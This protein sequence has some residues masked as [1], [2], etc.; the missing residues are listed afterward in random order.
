MAF[1]IEPLLFSDPYRKMIASLKK[2]FKQDAREEGI[3]RDIRAGEGKGRKGPTSLSRYVP[4]SRHTRGGNGKKS[5]P[6]DREEKED[7]D[8]GATAPA[9]GAV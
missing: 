2:M 5:G 1:F 4:K 6:A 3:L 9:D 7:R 8:S